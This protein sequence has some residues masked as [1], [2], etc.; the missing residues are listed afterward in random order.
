MSRVKKASCRDKYEMKQMDANRKNTFRV[1]VRIG[2]LDPII[3]RIAHVTL[4]SCVDTEVDPD[5]P[6]Y[7]D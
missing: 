4:P 2:K 6:F 5:N 3:K 7:S 1:V